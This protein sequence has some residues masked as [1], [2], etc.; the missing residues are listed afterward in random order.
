MPDSSKKLQRKAPAPGH[1]NSSHPFA[2]SSRLKV[3]TPQ[4]SNARS[5]RVGAKKEP[6]AEDAAPTNEKNGAKKDGAKTKFRRRRRRN[7]SLPIDEA[8]RYKGMDELEYAMMLGRCM[9]IAEANEDAKLMLEGLKEWGRQLESK[10]AAGASPG[11]EPP[12]VVQLVH[13][14]PRP[15]R[16]TPGQFESPS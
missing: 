16:S 8:L 6:H 4:Q 1:P 15:D 3:V 2:S 13:A 7:F 9:D 12:T 10:R 14:V 5:A 11:A